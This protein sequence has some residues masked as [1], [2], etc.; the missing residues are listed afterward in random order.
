V[1]STTSVELE[2]HR[3]AAEHVLD[4]H[5]AHLAHQV[6]PA[7]QQLEDGRQRAHRDLALAARRHHPLAQ[8]AGRRRDRDDHLVGL[9]AVE[10]PR[11]VVGRALHL[12]AVDAHA[13]LARVVVDEADRHAAELGVAAQLGRHQL[14][15]VARAHDQDL[16]R[17]LARD[18]AA[19]RAPLG[20]RADDEADAAHEHE[21]EQQVECDHPARRVGGPRRRDQE[22]D[23]NER[24]ARHHHR[25]H[26]ALEVLRVH[27]APELV[28]EPVRPED[29]DLA[30]DDEPDRRRQQVAVA[31][32]DRRVEAQHEREQVRERDEAGVDQRL[33]EAARDD[34]C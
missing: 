29:H 8:H 25:A 9:G 20:D 2:A 28:V 10:D 17:A 21:R 19:E 31:L 11:Q 34:R 32:R 30:R 16:A 7:R 12:Q 3:L 5:L 33:R 22:E 4:A 6:Q 18:R 14:A 15:A 24:G 1:T 23:R 26:D 27:E 13:L